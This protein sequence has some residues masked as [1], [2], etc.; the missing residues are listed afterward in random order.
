MRAFWEVLGYC[1]PWVCPKNPN[2]NPAC[3]E[4]IYHRI[5][6]HYSVWTTDFHQKLG[7]PTVWTTDPKGS[8]QSLRKKSFISMLM[9]EFF[10]M[11]DTKNSWHTWGHNWTGSANWTPPS[12]SLK[13]CLIPC[14]IHLSKN[15]LRPSYFEGQAKNECRCRLNWLWSF[16]DGATF[17]N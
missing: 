8:Q 5:R 3:S 15:V 6:D 2:R 13:L 9:R 7:W 14:K 12:K 4:T 1:W 11:P 17:N 16:R 10:S